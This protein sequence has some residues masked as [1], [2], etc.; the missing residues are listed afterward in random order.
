MV[1]NVAMIPSTTSGGMSQVG[2]PYTRGHGQGHGM[3]GLGGFDTGEIV[4][5][6]G[7]YGA[8]LIGAAFLYMAVRGARR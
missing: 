8:Y 7:Q 1:V 6:I 4:S 3:R 2:D 5:F